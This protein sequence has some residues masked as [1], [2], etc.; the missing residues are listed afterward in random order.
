MALLTPCSVLRGRVFVH[1]DCPRGRDFAPFKLCSKGLSWGG[2]VL[3]EIDTCI[4][5]KSLHYMTEQNNVITVLLKESQ[6]H[7]DSIMSLCVK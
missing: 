1:N 6:F 3:D 7:Q 5:V 4:R 2:M